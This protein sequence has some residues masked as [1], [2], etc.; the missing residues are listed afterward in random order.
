MPQ[1]ATVEQGTAQ[2]SDSSSEDTSFHPDHDA[3]WSDPGEAPKAESKPQAKAPSDDPKAADKPE[4][5]A[6]PKPESEAP[7]HNPDLVELALDLGATQDQIDGVSPAVLKQWV[8]DQNRAARQPAPAKKPDPEP[9]PDDADDVLD[10][11]EDGGVKKKIKASEYEAPVVH[12]FKTVKELRE[13]LAARERA[14]AERETAAR[15]QSVEDAFEALGAEAAALLGKGHTSEFKAESD[16]MFRRTAVF[17]T[18]NLTTADTPKQIA[19]KVKAAYERLFGK[20]PPAAKPAPAEAKPDADPDAFTPPRDDK[21]RFVPTEDAQ[22]EIR[23]WAAGG[24]PE[25]TGRAAPK[26]KVTGDAA[27]IRAVEDEF[28][29]LGYTPNGAARR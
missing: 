11:Y 14:D 4:P 18:A 3:V 23:K 27:A 7:R 9:E 22:A 1:D 25:P 6:E 13:K 17:R 29:K 8:R 19:A 21:G 24:L 15:F 5:K 28:R 26:P 16:E 12:L 20:A 10:E 2:K